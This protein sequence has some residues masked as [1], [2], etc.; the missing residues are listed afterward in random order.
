M[1]ERPSP[2]GLRNGHREMWRAGRRSGGA[3][4]GDCYAGSAGPRSMSHRRQHQHHNRCQPPSHPQ[5]HRSR[6]P[7]VQQITTGKAR[8]IAQ[9]ADMDGISPRFRPGSCPK[10]GMAFEPVDLS[11]T[12]ERVEYTCPIHP[13]IVR[14]QPGS[15]PICGMA[16]EPRNVTANASNP[17]LDDMTRRFWIGVVLTIPLLAVMASDILPVHPTSFDLRRD[18]GI[19]TGVLAIVH[20]A[21]VTVHLRGRMWMD[22]FKALQA[23]LALPFDRTWSEN[24]PGPVAISLPRLPP[25]QGIHSS[26][27]L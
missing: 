23:L 11:S 15:C 2:V 3:A 25:E 24:S 7:M 8:N 5:S 20:T 12:T 21:I 14:D 6:T 9:L 18:V 16:L 1:S 10:C 13:Q 4:T 19:W 26:G 22:C 17:E 27:Q